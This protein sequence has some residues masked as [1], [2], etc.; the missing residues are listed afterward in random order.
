LN[1]APSLT[2]LQYDNLKEKLV[3]KNKRVVE[4]EED[5]AK[6]NQKTEN[7]MKEIT[8]LKIEIGKV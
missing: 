3:A 4:L 2:S 8:F 1:L 6:E 7:M 5:L